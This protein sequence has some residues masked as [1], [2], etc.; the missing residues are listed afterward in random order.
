MNK[1]YRSSGFTL[2]ELIFVLSI[3]G[4]LVAVALPAYQDYLERA[5]LTEVMLE[6]DGMATAA[7]VEA[8]ENQL[9][10]CHW[11]ASSS[12]QPDDSTRRIKQI[13]DR[14]MDQLDPAYW[15]P[16]SSGLD[17]L[18]PAK[19]SALV[20]LYAGVGEQGVRRAELLAEM[21]MDNGLFQNWHQRT[22]SYAVFSVFLEHCKTA[23]TATT[24][25]SAVTALSPV[26]DKH[27]KDKTPDKIKQPT[28][29][30]PQ[31]PVNPPVVDPPKPDTGSAGPL[32]PVQPPVQVATPPTQP[33]QTPPT[34]QPAVQ[35]PAQSSSNP[36]GGASTNPHPA[37][38]ILSH[39]QQVAQC[40]A[41]C[42]RIWP[43]GNSNMYRHCMASCQ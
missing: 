4:I 9:D 23:P 34:G 27:G 10:L 7:R 21:F 6:F 2:I 36:P 11:V 22:P 14:G 41:N 33:G 5:E 29:P 16:S 18:D 12:S 3:M 26:G 38:S 42:R 32:T 37:S 24:V 13:V 15:S 30:V 39:A 20:V 19:A 28:T 31:S 17:A 43:H 25:V 35:P 40:Q 1:R 8:G